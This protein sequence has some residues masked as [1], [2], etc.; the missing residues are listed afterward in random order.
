MET[1]VARVG[2]AEKDQRCHRVCHVGARGPKRTLWAVR[3]MTSSSLRSPRADAAFLH[4]VP[5]ICAVPTERSEV[6][7]M[8]EKT[9]FWC[10]AGDWLKLECNVRYHLGL[11]WTDQ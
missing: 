11:A 4:L 1:Y 5:V 10:G 3:H 7:A 8:A 2:A 9:R 6:G